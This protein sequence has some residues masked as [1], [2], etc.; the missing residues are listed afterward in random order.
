[1]KLNFRITFP[2]IHDIAFLRAPTSHT[3]SYS[4]ALE[5]GFTGVTPQKTNMEPANELLE[6]E[7]MELFHPTYTPEASH[8]TYGT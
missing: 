8:G 5:I 3:W 1:M 2:K 6:E 7:T 4:L